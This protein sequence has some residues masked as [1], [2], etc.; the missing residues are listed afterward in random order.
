MIRVDVKKRLHGAAGELD[1]RLDFS[2]AEG[3]FILIGG[4]S[5]AGKTSLLRMIAGLLLPD[6]GRVDIKPALQPG[7]IGFVFQDY[8][9]FP[10]MTVAENLDFAAGA[11]RPEDREELLSA[12]ELTALHDRYPRQL[13]GGQ[14]QRVALARTLHQRPRLLLLDEAFSALDPALRPRVQ[15]FLQDRHRRAGLTTLAV[16]H[17]V[18]G[19]L[20][21]ADRVLLL[22]AGKLVFRGTPR[23]LLASN[24]VKSPNARVL[25]VTATEVVLQFGAQLLRLPIPP[26]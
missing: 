10:N 24:Q 25:E 7:D 20:L 23:E 15:T 14:R 8:G 1:L 4:P 5:G 21:L 12:L 26:R 17:D 9:L 11:D 3:E 6:E 13:S 19:S 18:Y 22:E 16:T 2:V